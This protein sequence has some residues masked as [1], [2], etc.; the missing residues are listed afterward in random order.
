MIM[1]LDHLIF[2][3]GCGLKSPRLDNVYYWLSGRIYTFS[4][5]LGAQLHSFQ[6]THPEPGERRT[7]LGREFVVFQSYRSLCRV[8]ASWTMIN[9]PEDLDKAHCEIRK[10]KKNLQA[11]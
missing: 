2:G 5:G 11:I 6:W 10:L 8:R 7:I 1:L 9:L 3:N 4:Y